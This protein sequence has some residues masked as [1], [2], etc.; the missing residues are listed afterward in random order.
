MTWAYVRKD[1]ASS[2]GSSVLGVTRAYTAGTAGNVLIALCGLQS[3]DPRFWTES[4]GWNRILSNNQMWMGWRVATGDTG[5]DLTVN[6]N[7]S[8]KML[9]GIFEFSGLNPINPIA[10]FGQR[11]ESSNY[12]KITTAFTPQD[13]GMYAMWLVVDRHDW[14]ANSNLG[15]MTTA[16]ATSPAEGSWPNYE[17]QGFNSGGGTSD[18]P[19]IA[20]HGGDTET[21]TSKTVTVIG[22]SGTAA[23]GATYV[24][25]ALNELQTP[26][27]A[28]DNLRLTE[29]TSFWELAME[30]QFLQPVPD[31]TGLGG[32]E[33]SE[34]STGATWYQVADQKG[35]RI[36]ATHGVLRGSHSSYQHLQGIRPVT[37]GN[38]KAEAHATYNP[39]TSLVRNG[40]G[41]ADSGGQWRVM[42][43]LAWS[44]G[45]LTN[46]EIKTYP[47]KTD[48]T[49]VIQQ[50]FT[51][52]ADPT[53]NQRYHIELVD[54]ILTGTIYSSD[55]LI[56]T[57]VSWDTGGD[58]SDNRICLYQRGTGDSTNHHWYYA[59][60]WKASYT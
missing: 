22:A 4:A 46:L 16:T 27:A 10:G 42:V 32:Q 49:G 43:T 56:P 36:R 58:W 59:K 33:P 23:V 54:G 38:I 17:E 52:V 20:F 50:A 53:W 14:W 3:D 44:G 24:G 57:T 21:L 8:S 51:P 25:L 40:L 11:A 18:R 26:P 45:A 6:I 19:G 9:L 47:G 2:W 31:Y 13:L 55:G 48:Y 37:S 34:L 12:E 30:D 29:S 5:D 60:L 15:D 39:S 35:F 28:P 1:Y 7:T 41:L